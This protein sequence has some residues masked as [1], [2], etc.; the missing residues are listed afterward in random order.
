M[1]YS[2]SVV[3]SGRFLRGREGLL[4]ASRRDIFSR[5]STN[6]S[7]CFT[8][9][10][11]MRGK[12]TRLWGLLLRFDFLRSFIESRLLLLPFMLPRYATLQMQAGFIGPLARR[13]QVF[14]V[15]VIV[16][17]SLSCVLCRKTAMQQTGLSQP[18]CRR[19]ECVG[20][21]APAELVHVTKEA[22]VSPKRCKTFEQ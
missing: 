16:K 5:T 19:G 1:H 14:P 7:E 18:L 2:H 8:A 13:A 12:V 15:R 22:G 10:L 3:K 21:A 20:G 4:L 6:M 11:T 9:V 17:Q